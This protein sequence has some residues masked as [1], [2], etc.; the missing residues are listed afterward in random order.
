MSYLRFFIGWLGLAGLL[1]QPVMA[2]QPEA[3][4]SPRSVLQVAGLS[5]SV[6][7][8]DPRVLYILPWQNPSLP[9]R[10]RAELNNRAP[11]LLQPAS[12]RVLENHRQFRDSLNPLV[13]QP[14]P[15]GAGQGQP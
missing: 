10:P 5:A 9:R 15:I 3:A 8:D 7:D 1:W 12:P 13:L 11:N 4:D 14:T 2:D 6:G